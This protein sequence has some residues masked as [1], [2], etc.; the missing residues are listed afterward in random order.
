MKKSRKKFIGKEDST[1]GIKNDIVRVTGF[2]VTPRTQTNGKPV[3]IK[4]TVA[5]VSSRKLSEVPWQILNGKKEIY[6]GS[7]YNVKAGESFSV[8]VSWTAAKGDHFFCADVDPKN[9]LHEPRIKQFN[10]LPQ[11][12]DVKVK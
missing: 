10:N 1:F 3:K 4:M 8:T 5:N 7:R 9:T 6:S 11:G 12:V 2:T